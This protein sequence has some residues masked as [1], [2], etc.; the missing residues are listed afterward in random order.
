MDGMLLV[1]FFGYLDDDGKGTRFHRYFRTL[2]QEAL[3]RRAYN[4]SGRK[5]TP[6][7]AGTYAERAAELN[8]IVLADRTDAQLREQIITK[9]KGVGIKL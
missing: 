3:T 8:K 1:Y 7:P 5:G 6:P 2:A 4:E 9:F